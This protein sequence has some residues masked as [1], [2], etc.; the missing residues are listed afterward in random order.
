MAEVETNESWVAE[1]TGLARDAA[2][3]LQGPSEHWVLEPATTFEIAIEPY[4]RRSSGQLRACLALISFLIRDVMQNFAGD[5][6]YDPLGERLD[7]A[8]ANVQRA[9]RFCLS[10][11]AKD[12][13]QDSED[14]SETFE[15]CS[16]AIG[17]Y[18]GAIQRL[19]AQEAR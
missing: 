16:T 9:L 13:E 14:L 15:S 17:E 8:R 2:D 18:L 1:I 3:G 11:L 4:I 19:N 10:T 7:I 5:V 6:P 12:L